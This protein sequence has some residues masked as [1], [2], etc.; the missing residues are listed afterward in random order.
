MLQK[1]T[2]SRRKK[3]GFNGQKAIVLPN[4]VIKGCEESPLIKN[5]FITDIGFYPKA[6]FHFRERSIGISQHILIYC[7]NGKGW[8][9]LYKQ[10]YEVNSGQFLVVPAGT[11]HQYGSDEFNPWSIYWLH[12][13]GTNANEVTALLSRSR[14]KFVNSVKFS[15][16]RI[17]L[18]SSMYST[19]ENGYSSDNLGYINMGLWYFLSSFCYDDI[20]HA[21][22]KKAEKDAIDLSI[23]FMQKKIEHTL[24]IKELAI[25]ANISPSHYACLFKK[26]TGYPPLEYF[27]QIKVQKACQYLQFTCLQIKEI[28]YKLGINDPYYFSRFFSNLM[29]MSPLEYRNKKH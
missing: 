12:F 24:T 7:I 23:E 18:F 15:E 10:E 13:K 3:E 6:Q 21:P 8:L 28:A 1:T 27:N 22:Y 9:Q 4:K 25:E 2:L 29:G 17:R 19:L 14:V 11:I 5:L 26:K 20:F 16:E